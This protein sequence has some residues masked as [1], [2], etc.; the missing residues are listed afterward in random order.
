MTHVFTI[1]KI[2]ILVDGLGLI[3]MQNSVQGKHNVKF[4]NVQRVQANIYVHPTM[5]QI[6]YDS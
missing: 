2:R 3:S 1:Q 5:A 4:Y 6:W